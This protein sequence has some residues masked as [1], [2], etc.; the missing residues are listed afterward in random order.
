MLG[1]EVRTALSWRCAQR[2]RSLEYLR[3][4][5]EFLPYDISAQGARRLNATHPFQH[6]FKFAWTGLCMRCAALVL[7]PV[8]R[9]V[10][11]CDDK[12][13]CE[14]GMLCHRFRCVYGVV[15]PVLCVCSHKVLV[16]WRTTTTT[17][18]LV[19][20]GRTA[21]VSRYACTALLCGAV[22]LCS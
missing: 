18:K 14:G 19:F 7:P 15:P 8:P 5:A 2:S 6:S 1:I 16:Q 17:N 22:L 10:R 3:I 11:A 20:V 13:Y 12:G 21:V 4:T 9:D